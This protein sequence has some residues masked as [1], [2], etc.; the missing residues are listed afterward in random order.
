MSM[1]DG[2]LGQLG[3]QVDVANLAEKVG[4]PADQVESV[5][6][7]LGL[8]HVA[9]GDTAEIAAAHTGLSTDMIQQIIAHIGGEGALGR[10]ASILQEQQ[11]AGF[12]LGK[13]AG[14]LTGG[15]GGLFGKA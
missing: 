7:T 14:G 3:G 8:A 2:I 15:L 1:F 9:E 11:G 5:I 13:L 12:D 4:L 6:Q 10:F